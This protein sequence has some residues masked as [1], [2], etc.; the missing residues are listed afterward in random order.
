M[1]IAIVIVFTG[2]VFAAGE[3]VTVYLDRCDT[4]RARGSHD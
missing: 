4:R 2:V 1:A 3:L